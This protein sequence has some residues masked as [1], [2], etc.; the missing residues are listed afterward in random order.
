MFLVCGE[1]LFDIFIEPQ[2]SAALT[3]LPL[4]GVAGGSPF[5]VAIGL[6][7]LEHSVGL[8]TG[9]SQDLFGDRLMSV[10]QDEQVNTQC[11]KHKAAPATLSFIQKDDNGAANYAFYGKGAADRSLTNEDLPMDQPFSGLHFGSYTLVTPPTADAFYTLAAHNSGKCLISLDPN[12]R[13]GVEPDK[14]QWR[15]RVAAMIPHVNILKLSDEDFE[16]LYPDDALESKAQ[17]WLDNGV[18]IVVY[19]QGSEG[20]R[21]FSVLAE[22]TVDAPRITVMDTVG[23]GDTV[24]TSLIDQILGLRAEQDDW[25]A[26]L[27]EAMLQKIGQQAA[28]SAAITCSRKGADLPRRSEV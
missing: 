18:G 22:T 13:L 26:L 17:E 10:L 9:L 8:L 23:A 25:A 24:Q 16:A 2:S 4:D 11:I 27:N 15:K 12:I 19:T 28:R 3:Q 6:A 21:L 1:A 7:R 5:N 20:L 14:N